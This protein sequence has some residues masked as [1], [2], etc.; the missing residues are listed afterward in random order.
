MLH[1]FC[2]IFVITFTMGN[3]N[4]KEKNTY[5]SIA[6]GEHKEKNG[7]LEQNL[8][9]MYTPRN[10]H[11]RRSKKVVL[12]D[13]T[14][15]TGGSIL[16]WSLFYVKLFQHRCFPVNI[17]KFLTTLILKNICERLLLN[18]VSD[19]NEEQHLLAHWWNMVRYN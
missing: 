16:C 10:S 13:F 18:A 1:F 11:P 5:H 14:I 17:A 9:R 6:I 2:R 15:F 12:K 3:I 4:T 8:K 7:K 19:N